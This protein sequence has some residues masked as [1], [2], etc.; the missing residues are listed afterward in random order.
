MA[1]VYFYRLR[2]TDFDGTTYDYAPVQVHMSDLSSMQFSLEAAYPNPLNLA[3]TDNA[4]FRYQVPQQSAVRISVHDA[5]GRELAVLTD[6]VHDAGIHE[7]A[8]YPGNDVLR[9][10][11]YFVRMQANGKTLTRKIAVIR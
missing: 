3:V 9:S 1:P 10:G 2:Q 5:L 7:T 6:Y 4:R 8:W 11:S